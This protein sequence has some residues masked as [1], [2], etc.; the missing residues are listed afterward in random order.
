MICIMCNRR[1][2][3]AAIM[4]G[5]HPVGPKCAKK[6]GLIEPRRRKKSEAE[7]DGKTMDLFEKDDDE[8]SRH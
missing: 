8:K 4:L 6:R 1:M 2:L 7:R 5:G 3:T